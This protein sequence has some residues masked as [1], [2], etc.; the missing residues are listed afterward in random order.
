V[1]FYVDHFTESG[2]RGPLNW[3][4]NMDNNWELT[5][6]FADRKI[7]Q[8]AMFMHGDRDLVPFNSEIEGAFRFMVPNLWKIIE[9][10]KIGH[11]TAQEAPDDV[12]KALLEFLASL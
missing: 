9:L 11:W 10:P 8:P 12:N 1:Q 3:Y 2:F 4:R 7:E 5:K 6:A